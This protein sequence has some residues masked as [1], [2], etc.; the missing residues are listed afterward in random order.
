MIGGGVM[1]VP[2]SKEL[3]MKDGRRQEDNS[4]GKEEEGSCLSHLLAWVS[5]QRELV[6]VRGEEEEEEQESG[7][8]SSPSSPSSFLLPALPP[9]LR[10]GLACL[11]GRGENQVLFPGLCTRPQQRYGTEEGGDAG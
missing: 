10:L 11:E 6:L 9:F 3:E 8:E 2:M 1:Q 7:E 5:V 4:G